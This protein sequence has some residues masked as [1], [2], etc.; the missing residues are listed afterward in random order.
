MALL[1]ELRFLSPSS[2]NLSRNIYRFLITSLVG[3]AISRRY[4]HFKNSSNI[5]FNLTLVNKGS[6]MHI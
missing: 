5:H 2:D 4:L 6:D 3:S 1:A